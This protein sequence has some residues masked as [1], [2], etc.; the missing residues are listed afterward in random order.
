[1]LEVGNSSIESECGFGLMA[2][3]LTD[4]KICVIC[5]G[6]LCGEVRDI[7]YL[8]ANIKD[9]I[10]VYGNLHTLCTWHNILHCTSTLNRGHAR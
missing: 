10:K 1:M 9:K 6:K 5:C 2:D 3:S 8:E 7:W 4:I